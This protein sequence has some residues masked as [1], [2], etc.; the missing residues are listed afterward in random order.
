[1]VHGDFVT[2]AH[3]IPVADVVTLDRVVCCYTDYK[4]L[5]REAVSRAR[6]GVALSYPRDRWFVRLGVGIENGVRRLR[7]S[8]F[9][10]FVHPADDMHRLIR[11]AGFDLVTRSQTPAWAVDVYA[12]R[13]VA[14][15]G[16]H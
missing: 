1:L 11:D 7:S 15:G 10:A 12:R 14:T 5:L 3:Q 8:A 16:A 2:I 9:R 13:S 6:R 4:S